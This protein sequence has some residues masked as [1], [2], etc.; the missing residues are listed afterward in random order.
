[1]SYSKYKM[2]LS[3]NVLNHLGLNLYSNT[4]AV[5]SEVIAN[6]WDADATEVKIDFDL[7]E[8]TI[9]VSDNGHGMD[10]YDI[11][12]KYLFVGYQKR[13]KRDKSDYRTPKGRR[14]MGRKGIG[15]LSLFSIAN[16]IFV[17]SY[18]EGGKEESF[19]MDAKKIKEAI[20]P[21]GI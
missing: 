5:L 8:K 7:E 6:A 18:K 15:K 9:T 19:L 16:K 2:S 13:D 12:N 17:Y 21:G 11:N 14:P 20:I 10:L 4:P 1:M 3:L